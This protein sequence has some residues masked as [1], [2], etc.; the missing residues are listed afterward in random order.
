MTDKQG[1]LQ[2]DV[3]GFWGLVS[4]SLAGMAPSCDVVAFMTAGAAFALVAMPLS[5]L[6]AFLLMFI[7]VNTLYHLSKDRASAGGYYSYVSAGLGPRAALVTGFMVVFY[8][9]LSVAGIPVYIG[10]VFLPGLA[11]RLHVA[12]PA[13]F[14]IVAVL[15]F[16]GVPWLLAVLGIR[17]SIKVLATTSLVEI[18]FLIVASII[19]MAKVHPS[20]PLVPFQFGSV[21][22]K[23]VAMGM[24]FAITSFIGIGSH[25]SLGEEAKGV[26]TQQGRLIGKAA[27][28]SLTLTGV[29][30]TL[31]AYALTVGWGMFRMSSFSTAN[32]PGVTVFLHYLGPVGAASLVI[33]ALNS[34]LADSIALLTSSSRVL[35]A[36]GRDNL[37]NTGFAQVNGRRAPGR[38][39]TLLAGIAVVMAVVAGSLL[40]PSAAFNVMTTAVL[41]GLVTS[42]TLMNVSLM[43][44]FRSE[45][46]QSHFLQHVV[47]PILAIGLFWIVLY[48]SVWPIAY[49]LSLSAL[50][51][52]VVLIPVVFYVYGISKR[53][54][55]ERGHQLGMIP[56]SESAQ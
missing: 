33:L 32:A 4:Q 43:R 38:S 44:L 42:H 22:I 28:V 19:I 1:T 26:R 48:E 29:A 30:L 46:K 21:G 39:V 47:L 54:P 17:P 50:I 23:G 20:H 10:G 52:I 35:F 7:E 27:L 3:V 25:S 18:S 12:L 5:F 11:D 14:W 34:A 13:Y 41:F 56:P 24:V 8:Q 49:P 36:I 37:V 40:G 53:I 15:F 16:I 9:I 31:S 2:P 45:H 51:W 55:K 6:L